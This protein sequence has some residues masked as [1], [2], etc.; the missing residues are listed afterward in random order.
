MLLLSRVPDLRFDN[1]CDSPEGT[2][3]EIYRFILYV[4][5]YKD[6]MTKIITISGNSGSGKTEIG[7]LLTKR[8]NNSKFI[9]FDENDDKAIFPES[10]PTAMPDEY[11]LSKLSV[12]LKKE[13]NDSVNYI[14][15][16]YPFGRANAEISRLIDISF[17]LQV[18]IDV[19]MA[20]MTRRELKK[21]NLSECI[22]LL[23]ELDSW[24]NGARDFNIKWVDW[25]SKSCD[26]IID[27]YSQ[28][29]IIVNEI[30]G[31]LEIDK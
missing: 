6:I 13:K 24:E 12:F 14:I 15:F 16:D 7:K 22:W 9:S 8:L 23:S 17:F 1:P 20:R 19:S 26:F 27:A 2:S 10:Y 31:K 30:I 29:E 25:V 4:F 18:P 3:D 28:P 11:D 21:G 5:L